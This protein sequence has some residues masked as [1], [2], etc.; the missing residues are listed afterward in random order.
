VEVLGEE[1]HSSTPQK[2]VDAIVAAAHV[3]LAL[4][5]LASRET[6]PGEAVA[7]NIGSVHGGQGPR[8]LLADRVTLRGLVRASDPALRADLPDRVRRIAHHAA[9]ALRARCEVQVT[10][11][12]PYVAN[13][14]A[15][16]ERFVAAVGAALG[17]D[18]VQHLAGPRLVGESF[19]AYSERVPSVFAFLGTG[20]PAKPGTTW[21]SHHP[22]FDLDEDALAPGVLAL[23]D[24]ALDL[25][26]DE[27]SSR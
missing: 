21:P 20:N 1:A 3:I 23:A 7:V 4:Q 11:F 18:R 12:L 13:D 17:R 10:P 19:F 16:T 25:L 24:A 15:L 27:G 2:G 8:N 9:A 14:P 5:S 6:D 26:R 22:R